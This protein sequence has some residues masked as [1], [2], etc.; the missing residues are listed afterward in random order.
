ML[1][2]TALQARDFAIRGLARELRRDAPFLHCTSYERVFRDERAPMAHFIFSDV[3]ML[4]P[5]EQE[6]AIAVADALRARDP[7][8]RIL[9]DP[10]LVLE[11]YPLLRTLQREGLNSFT[12]TRLD[13][14]D[15]PPRYPVF[16]RCE[17]NHLGTDTALI[18][19][20]REFEAALAAL[21]AQGKVLKRRIAV[22]FRAQPGNDGLYRKYG[23]FN[24]GGTLVP[25]HVLRSKHWVV[26]RRSKETEDI[27]EDLAFIEEN[28]HADAIQKVFEMA[29]VDYGRIDYTV[30]DGRIEVYEINTNPKLPHFTG[31]DADSPPART[32]RR[33][34]TRKRFVEA[35]RAIDTPLASRHPVRFRLPEPRLEIRP[36]RP[37]ARRVLMELLALYPSAKAVVPRRYW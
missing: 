1:Y 23:V 19:D 18:H 33:E 28:P 26:K 13:G 25:Q 37:R 32:K 20:D 27:E 17:D 30:I 24:L 35:L 3:D 9:N 7:N 16:I 21:R 11:R 36:W 12:V 31:R 2:L 4:T 8:V 10:R 34:M 14:G 15:R 5:Y 6:A 22:E 29:H